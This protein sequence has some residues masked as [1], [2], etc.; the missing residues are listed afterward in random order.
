VRVTSFRIIILA[1][2]LLAAC[3]S[4][5]SPERPPVRLNETL[6]NEMSAIPELEPMDVAIDSFRRYWNLKGLNF[7]VMRNDSLLYAKGYGWADDVN[8]EPML[9]GT[10]LR[11]ASVSKLLTAIAIMKLS[12]EGYFSLQSPVFGPFGVLKGFDDDIKDERYYLITVEHILRHQAGFH[13]GRNDPMFTTA[14]NM[15]AM[16]LSTPPTQE[17][18]AHYLLSFRLDF[19]PGTSQYYSNFG[20]MLLGMIVEQATGKTY[21]RYMQEDLFEPNGCFGFE[22]AGNYQADRHPGESFYYLQPDTDLVPEYTGSGRY[23]PR[24]YGGNDVRTLGGA[25]A[26]T[27]SA[28]ELARLVATIDGRGPIADILSEESL[29]RMAIQEGEDAYPLGWMDSR[30]GILTRTGTLSGTSALIKLYPDGECWIMISNT[31]SWRG[32]QFTKN[33]AALFE[34]LRS[35]FD[36]KFPARDL[37]SPQESEEST[38]YSER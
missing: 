6:T 12:E 8:R 34:K 7:A 15:R 1:G 23:V 31:S 21:A 28:P 22:I 36:D 13:N 4:G 38:E 20:Y 3:A 17:Q 11:L 14:P 35:R 19:D 27:G 10:T 18:L 24:T 37:F 9:P 2:L 25:G 33:M 32:S 5:K 30:D 26:W 29:Y 16:G